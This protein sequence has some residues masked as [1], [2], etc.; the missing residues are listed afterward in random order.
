MLPAL[1]ALKASGVSKRGPGGG[2]P[3]RRAPG[4]VPDSGPRLALPA[5]ERGAGLAGP[6]HVVHGPERL[7]RGAALAPLRPGARPPRDPPLGA[8]R[9]AQRGEGDRGLREG[10][11]EGVQPPPLRPEG[12]PRALAADLPLRALRRDAARAG[13]PRARTAYYLTPT[14]PEGAGGDRWPP[15]SRRTCLTDRPYLFAFLGTSRTQAHKRW[16]AKNFLELSRAVSARSGHE[17]GPGVGARGGGPRREPP[18][19]RRPRT[20]PRLGPAR[21][22]RGH[23]PRPRPSWAPTREPCTWRRSWACPPWP[24]WDPPTRSSTG[25]SERRSGW[26]TGRASDGRAP[27]EGCSHGD[28][29]AALGVEEACPRLR[30]AARRGLRTRNAG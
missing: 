6:L 19:G 9:G 25:P 24:S 22:P 29:M 18:G 14:M 1:T 26:F 30:R 15:S 10:V 4:P 21:A 7:P 5:A 8:P 17:D 11:R 12:G 2:G 3:V 13:L 16:P 27:G 23:P 28:C 20:H